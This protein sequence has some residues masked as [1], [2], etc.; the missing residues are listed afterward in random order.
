[1]LAG[2]IVAAISVTA[3][4]LVSGAVWIAAKGILEWI[5]RLF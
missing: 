3:T 4:V 1:V 2:W 5:P